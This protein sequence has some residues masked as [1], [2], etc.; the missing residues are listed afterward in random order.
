MQHDLPRWLQHFLAHTFFLL[1]LVHAVSCIQYCKKYVGARG[2]ENEETS[3]TPTNPLL[4]P[5]VHRESGH[6][7]DSTRVAGKFEV[8]SRLDCA[9]AL[10][11]RLNISRCPQGHFS[12]LLSEKA[13]QAASLLLFLLSTT[14]LLPSDL[15]LFISRWSAVMDTAAVRR[16]SAGGIVRRTMIFS[17]PLVLNVDGLEFCASARLFI[18][19]F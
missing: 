17:L 11:F 13:A 10:I 6:D 9:F 15:L 5:F 1:P 14:V 8:Q 12:F 2:R 4:F 19:L 16:G 18:H 7:T 3:L